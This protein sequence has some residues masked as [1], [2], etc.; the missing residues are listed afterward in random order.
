MQIIHGMSLHV[1]V[2]LCIYLR[3]SISNHYKNVQALHVQCEDGQKVIHILLTI[4]TGYLPA[5]S[6]H[7]FNNSTA[8]LVACFE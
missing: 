6:W 7:V 2:C 8:A 3:D 4:I 1:R 5:A